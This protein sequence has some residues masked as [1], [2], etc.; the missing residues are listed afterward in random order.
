MGRPVHHDKT[1]AHKPRTNDVEQI[2]GPDDRS[3]GLEKLPQ[4]AL[5]GV[6][7]HEQVEAIAHHELVPPTESPK[8]PSEEHCHR[9]RFIKLNG[10]PKNAV[11]EIVGPGEQSRRSIRIVV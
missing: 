3:I 8:E 2:E 1:V 4:E 10:M 9:R 5:S 11:A 6:P 7:E